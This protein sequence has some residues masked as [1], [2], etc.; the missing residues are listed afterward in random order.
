MRDGKFVNQLQIA[1]LTIFIIILH[2]L[3]VK[4]AVNAL[5][6]CKLCK[7]CLISYQNWPWC[8]G[9]KKRLHFFL[10]Q[11]PKGGTRTIVHLPI[12]KGLSF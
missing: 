8:N 10:F 7:D 5:R 9:V 1:E 6:D 12:S 4:A 2:F 3:L 11:L